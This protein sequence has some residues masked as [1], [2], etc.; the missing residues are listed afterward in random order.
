MILPWVSGQAWTDDTILSPIYF[1]A[2]GDPASV[3]AEKGVEMPD[4]VENK[5]VEA[6]EDHV[7]QVFS[8]FSTVSKPEKLFIN[9]SNLDNFSIFPYYNNWQGCLTFRPQNPTTTFR[10]TS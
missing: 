1:E 7:L 10:V 6:T 4:G 5:V 2:Q 3:L 8:H 9:R